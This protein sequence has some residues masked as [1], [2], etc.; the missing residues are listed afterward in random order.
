MIEIKNIKKSYGI[1]E[2]KTQIFGNKRV[3]DFVPLRFG[4]QTSFDTF[5]N[6]AFGDDLIVFDSAEDEG[7]KTVLTVYHICH[8]LFDGL[9][10]LNCCIEIAFL[11]HFLDHP[12]DECTKEVSL[13]ELENSDG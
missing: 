2:N 1:G 11:I 12:V 9:N 4:V 8:A 10:E 7:V 3:N 5:D 6:F 13:S